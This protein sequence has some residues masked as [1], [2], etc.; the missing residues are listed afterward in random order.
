MSNAICLFMRTLHSN[1]VIFQQKPSKKCLTL[2]RCLYIPI[3]LYSNKR[4][5]VYEQMKDLALHSN[6]VIFQRNGW[7]RYSYVRI[8][9]HSNLVIFQHALKLMS[10]LETKLYI[11][12]WLYSNQASS[13]V[14]TKF[15]ETFTF[16]SGYI[17]T[18]EYYK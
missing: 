18:V 6:L 3:W 4:E 8:T 2:E 7:F 12:I 5:K 14:C 13:A 1:L 17:P 16:Q 10:L 11:P 9:L 15:V